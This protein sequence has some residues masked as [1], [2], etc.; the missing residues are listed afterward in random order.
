MNPRAT[1]TGLMVLVVG[2]LVGLSLWS[3]WA[4]W[5]ECRAAGHSVVY[6]WRLVM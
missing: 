3:S 2:L 6:C 5:Q 1:M 4:I